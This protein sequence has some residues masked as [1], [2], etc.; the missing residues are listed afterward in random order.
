MKRWYA[1]FVLLTFLPMTP[2]GLVGCAKAPPALT[3]PAQQAFYKTEALKSLDLLRDFAISAEAT[4]PKV[5]PTSTTR[6]VVET[7][8]SIVLIM[9]AADT[10]WREAVITTLKE[11]VARRSDSEKQKLAPYVAL[12]TVLLTEIR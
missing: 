1:L 4:T 12:I 10:G 11:L 9:R 8:R 6:D 5:L 3:P 2:G 7:H